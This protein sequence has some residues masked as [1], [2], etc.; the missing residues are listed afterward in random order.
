MVMLM[1]F[2]ASFGQ[3]AKVKNAPS[4]HDV[5]QAEDLTQGHKIDSTDIVMIGNSLVEYA[6]NWSVLLGVK[7]VINRG[8]PDDDAEDLLNKLPQILQGHPKAIFLMVGINDLSRNISVEQVAAMT[9]KII[10]K[11][12]LGSF[13]TKLFVQSILPI[14][15]SFGVW[16]NLDGKSEDIHQVNR[17][18]SIYA[19]KHC[20][21]YIN[22][23]PCFVRHGTSQMRKELTQDGLHLTP[24][25]YK[26]W[27]FEIRKYMKTF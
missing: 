16:P 9:E 23:Y 20:I 2:A 6:G 21:S 5:G 11:I 1:G 15:E 24:L 25:G 7:N 3:V 27:A 22:I 18:V 19:K 12:H 17:L 26:I 8:L 14:N 13:N 10:S 4:K